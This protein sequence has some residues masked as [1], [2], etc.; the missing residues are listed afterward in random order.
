MLGGLDNLDPAVRAAFSAD[1]TVTIDPALVRT[2][3]E[4]IAG[5]R[6]PELKAALVAYLGRTRNPANFPILKEAYEMASSDRVRAAAIGALG[7]LGEHSGDFILGV[8][9]DAGIRPDLRRACI[10]ALGGMKYRR[11]TNTLIDLLEEDDFRPEAARALGRIAGENLG[12]RK[13]VWIR[14]LKTQP[15]IDGQEPPR[16]PDA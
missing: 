7:N 6:S 1:N 11:A 5:A 8:L 9:E 4:G 13:A 10:H 14:W 16:D 2:I 15:P 3:I 12:D